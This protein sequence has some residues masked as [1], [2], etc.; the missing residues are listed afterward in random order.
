MSTKAVPVRL[1]GSPQSTALMECGGSP[2][3]FRHPP[4]SKTPASPNTGRQDR[5]STCTFTFADG[6]QCRTPRRTSHPYLCVFH[7]RKEAQALAG[8]Q[9]GHDIA[10]FL[11]G[12]YI[13]A[14][15][16]GHIKPKTAATL[17][18]LGQT[19]V[20]TLKLAQHEYCNAFGPNA[21]RA[22]IRLIAPDPLADRAP[23]SR[24]PPPHPPAS[25]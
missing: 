8:E 13:S 2:P 10:S 16:Q 15:A 1:P 17:A 25:P 4:P 23:E 21:R 6:R 18:Y 20:Q 12:D 7:A 9:A 3:L 22:A 5:A 24:P 19:L 11:T 14:I